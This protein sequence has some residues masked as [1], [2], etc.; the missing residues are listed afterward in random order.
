MQCS[1]Y[2]LNVVGIFHMYTTN[3]FL[4]LLE[5]IKPLWF[6]RNELGERLKKLP[7]AWLHYP[8]VFIEPLS[9]YC[10]FQGTYTYWD[11]Y[12]LSLLAGFCRQRVG[13]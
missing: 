11:I 3:S 10:H 12:I 2:N 13:T 4:V 9:L 8:Q 7:I 1:R 6:K 5:C